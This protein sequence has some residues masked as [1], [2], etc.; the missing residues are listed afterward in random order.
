MLLDVK[1]EIDI[2]SLYIDKH[3]RDTRERLLA[4]NNR[5]RTQ[6]LEWQSLH[7]KVKRELDHLR[8]NVKHEKEDIEARA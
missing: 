8:I 5:L 2:Q 4:D 6:C 3:L 1:S 7:G